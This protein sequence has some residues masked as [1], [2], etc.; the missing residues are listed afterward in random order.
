[1]DKSLGYFTMAVILF[2][3]VLDE[4]FGR[5]YISQFVSAVIPFAD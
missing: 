3:L 1:M 5:K 4:V 2:W